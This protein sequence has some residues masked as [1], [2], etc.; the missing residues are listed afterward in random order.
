MKPKFP[1]I[2]SGKTPV[3]AISPSWFRELRDFC[4]WAAS[5]PRGDGSTILNTGDGTIRA[6]TRG[7][8]SGGSGRSF[9]T[10]FEVFAENGMLRTGPGFL[11]CNG[12]FSTVAGQSEIEPETGFLCVCSELDELGEWSPPELRIETPSNVAFPVAYIVVTGD[13]KNRRISVYQYPV[14]VAFL[15][16]VKICPIAEI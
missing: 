10:S 2:P 15:F 7:G 3:S 9:A 4:E 8:G 5:H 14:S 13:G 16:Q 6:V 1:S 12:A 11:C